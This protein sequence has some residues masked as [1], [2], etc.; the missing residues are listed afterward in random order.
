MK[1]L[2]GTGSVSMIFLSLMLKDVLK[3]F[4]ISEQEWK[5]PCLWSLCTLL[6]SLLQPVAC[7]FT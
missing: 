2:S 1:F 5:D 6:Q 4:I 7:F 3:L